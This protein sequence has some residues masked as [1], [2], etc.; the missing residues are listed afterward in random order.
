[1][2]PALPMTVFDKEMLLVQQAI[3]SDPDL[4]LSVELHNRRYDGLFEERNE[5]REIDKS[6]C[7]KLQREL[8]DERQDFENDVA[9]YFQETVDRENE[10]IDFFNSHQWTPSEEAQIRKTYLTPHVSNMMRRYMLSILG[11]QIGKRTEFRA[12]GR[13][14]ESD[15]MAEAE[16]YYLRWAAQINDYSRR[17]SLAFRD[18]L[19]GGRGVAMT[20]LDPDDPQGKPFFDYCRPQEFMFDPI[21]AKD[22]T[23]RGS[24]YLW[25]GYAVDAEDLITKYPLW[26]REIRK[27][28]PFFFGQQ[29]KWMWTMASPKVHATTSKKKS[30]YRYQNRSSRTGRKRIW[31][32]EFYRRRTKNSFAVYDSI[33]N[34]DHL[35]DDVNHATY[36]YHH[37]ASAYAYALAASGE[38]PSQQVVAPPRQKAVPVV[39][40]EIWAG[41]TLIHYERLPG[42]AF[43][44]HHFIPEMY[45]G[46]ITS[47]FG[48]DKNHQ[49]LRNRM[50]IY[51]DMLMSGIKG[52]T[53]YDA[54]ALPTGMTP[55]KFEENLARPTKA[56]GLKLKSDKKLTDIM[57]HIDPPNHGTLP[58]TIM[59]IAERGENQMLGGLN[60]IGTAE[61][62]GQSGKAVQHLIASSQ[63]AMVD[64]FDWFDHFGV[65]NGQS[66]SYMGQFISPVR[67]MMTIDRRN[68]PV[69]SR[70]VDLNVRSMENLEFDIQI[71]E[72]MAGP[73]ERENQYNLM[74]TWLQNAPEML[75]AAFPE[76]AELIGV[77]PSRRERIEQRYQESKQFKNILAQREQDRKDFEAEDS[78][79]LRHQEATR[80]WVE[81]ETEMHPPVR[82]TMSLRGEIGPAGQAS[83]LEQ[84]GISADPKGVAA[85]ISAGKLI[86]QAERTMMQEEWNDHL[87]PE[88]REALKGK[89]KKPKG[90]PSAKDDIA[91]KNK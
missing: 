85:D 49:R 13:D 71:E 10:D 75:E 42:D 38:D 54:T 63:S 86:N 50:L 28:D 67:K 89:T 12:F 45:N 84:N 66:L 57:A 58:Q 48:H 76:M 77:D 5:I 55:E 29:H 20:G 11:E 19:I 82:T 3:A 68:R 32:I 91:R 41:D 59:A 73:R 61:Y 39:D 6:Q 80:K 53:F 30:P 90:A 16:N 15:E 74:L 83:V 60:S 35:F 2:M 69:Y 37:L 65:E 23:L 36:F 17:E 8:L 56:I 33:G 24:K 47:F 14:P 87:L 81:T 62:A 34:I 21:S 78:S 26:E 22:G 31:I 72:V 1:M 46:E 40:Q 79:K 7:I 70:F 64:V 43:P 51:L 4:A 9:G 44:Y 52:K 27:F 25:R 88:Q 18:G